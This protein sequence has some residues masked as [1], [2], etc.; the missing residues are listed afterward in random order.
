MIGSP[1]TPRSTPTPGLGLGS[2]R[3]NNNKP[4]EVYR[5][6]HVLKNHIVPALGALRLDGIGQP[7][8]EGYKAQKLQEG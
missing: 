2:A 3:E 5:K 4:S 7:E 1:C 8:I 6:R